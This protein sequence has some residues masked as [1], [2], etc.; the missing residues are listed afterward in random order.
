MK[1]KLIYAG[2][3]LAST[4]VAIELVLLF[5]P[6]AQ[7]PPKESPKAI[8][9]KDSVAVKDS[10]VNISSVASI[11]PD[12]TD[13]LTSKAAN[14]PTLHDSLKVLEKQLEEQ[15]RLV[16]SLQTQ[17]IQ[18]TLKKD[19]TKTSG[20]KN[21]AKLLESMEAQGAAKILR[22]M[23]DDEVKQI[24]TY[25]KKRQ[26]GKVLSSLDPERVARIMR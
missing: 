24:I 6:H 16:A 7:E 14:T 25:M 3:F 22:N 15:R 2:L 9:A 17:V 18:D 8:I 10:T 1:S 26:A 23:N 20:T 19:S 5:A 21:L 4:I 11:Q 12:S 13:S